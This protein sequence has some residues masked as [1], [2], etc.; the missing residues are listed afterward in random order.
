MRCLR[1]NLHFGVV[2]ELAGGSWNMT[3]PVVLTKTQPQV[4]TKKN[5]LA[6][7]AA[8]PTH[9]SRII[10]DLV[11]LRGGIATMRGRR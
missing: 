10:S 7:R 5:E 8:D 11:E 3:C 6:C 4:V 1:E 2:P 9:K